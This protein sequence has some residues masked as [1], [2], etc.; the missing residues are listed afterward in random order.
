[1]SIFSFSSSGRSKNSRDRPSAS[2]MGCCDTPWRVTVRKPMVS[3]A[4]LISRA[5]DCRAAAVP[6]SDGAMSMTGTGVLMGP[7]NSIAVP[8]KRRFHARFQRVSVE[9]RGRSFAS[10]E[11]CGGRPENRPRERLLLRP[12]G[13]GETDIS[14]DLALALG[15][16]QIEGTPAHEHG[17]L[18]G[19]D[20]GLS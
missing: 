17:P 9:A 1:M 11:N 7:D 6:H 3:Q 10:A 5:T 8:W 19:R 14:R 15:P 12:F 18:V 16:Q 4:R 2:S 20:V 13:P